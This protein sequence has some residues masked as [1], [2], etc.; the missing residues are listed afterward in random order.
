MTQHGLSGMKTAAGRGGSQRQIQDRTYWL[1][2]LRS[3]I[4][5]LTSEMRKMDVETKQKQEENNTFLM[6]EKR[7]ELLAQEV[8]QIRVS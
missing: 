4:N 6:F 3:K 7:A 2:E 1:G 5:A 8:T